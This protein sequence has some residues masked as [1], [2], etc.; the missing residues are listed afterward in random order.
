MMS[1]GDLT[2]RQTDAAAQNAE[3]LVSSLKWI[4]KKVSVY[5]GTEEIHFR[6][7]RS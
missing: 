5:N 1:L 3:Q 7:D 2:E 6:G 4:N